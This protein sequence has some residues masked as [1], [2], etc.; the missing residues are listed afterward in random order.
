VDEKKIIH[1]S[2]PQTLGFRALRRCLNFW[3]VC[4]C[5]CW[6]FLSQTSSHF[7]EFCATRF[8]ST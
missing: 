5:A 1:S 7:R 8:L 3:C 6:S 4:S 2:A